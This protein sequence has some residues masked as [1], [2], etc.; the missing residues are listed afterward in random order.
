MAANKGVKKLMIYKIIVDIRI[1]NLD[2][3]EISSLFYINTAREMH[4]VVTTYH[5]ILLL[6]NYAYSKTIKILTYFTA[7]MQDIL[8]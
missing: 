3:I 6:L 8:L 2:D 7:F 1:K 5:A 4:F